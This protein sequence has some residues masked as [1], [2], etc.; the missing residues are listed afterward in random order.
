MSLLL[1]IALPTYNRAQLL[2]R[3]LEWLSSSVQKNDSEQVEILISNNH[4]TDETRQVI[5]KWQDSFGEAKVVVNH[6]E[7]NVGAIR[8]IAY[9]MNNASGKYVWVISDDD[10]IKDNALDFV[11]DTLRQNSDLALIILNFDAK[12]LNTGEIGFERCFTVD[13][14]KIIT[15]GKRVFS[16][17]LLEYYGGVTLTTALVY[18]TA[19]T[20]Q[21]IQSWPGGLDNLSIQTYITGFCALQG[22]ATV[23]KDIFLTCSLGDHFFYADPHLLEQMEFKDKPVMYKKLAKIGYRSTL[24]Q[25][26]ITKAWQ[27]LSNSLSDPAELG[28]FGRRLTRLVLSR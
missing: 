24:I 20:Q 13:E 25:I 4:S 8:N 21:A 27:K 28:N 16:Q 1:T 7:T 19:A 2:D 17:C 11:L 18:L 10:P 23:T 22:S 14:D 26:F 9:C 12:N 5:E 15:Q 6:Q 3:Q